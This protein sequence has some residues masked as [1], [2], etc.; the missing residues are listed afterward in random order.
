MLIV[1]LPEDLQPDDEHAT[2]LHWWLLDRE[3]CL[4]ESGCDTPEN[5]RGRFTGQRLRA[6]APATAV[7]LYRLDMPLRRAA[8]VRAALPFA[9]EDQLS[10]DLDL[11][12][13]VPGPRRSDGRLAAAVVETER[14]ERWQA[15]FDSRQWRLEALIPLP[16]LHGDE[17]P[18]QGL[19]VRPSP[20]PSA[21]P[22]VLITAP[23]E[24]P[25]L[26]ET[27]MLR[28]WLTRRLGTLPEA[29]RVIQAHGLSREDL[30]LA[31][32]QSAVFSDDSGSVDL[33]RALAYCLQPSPPLNLLTGPFVSTMAAPPWRKMRPAMV[34][35]G[36]LLAVLLAQFSLEWLFMARERDRL[37]AGIETVFQA[38]LPNSRMVQPVTQFRQVLDGNAPGSSQPGS[39]ALLHEALAV[40]A[41]T[42]NAEVKQFRFSPGELEVELQLTSFAELEAL[43][44][45][46]AAKPR[47]QETLQGADSGSEGVTA[48]LKVSRRAS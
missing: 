29:E 14:M 19:C 42:P 3:G 41:Q 7:S 18:S 40:I 25:V 38:S 28:L 39:S 9:L 13:C 16:I 35:A 12:H 5:L 27:G 44:A 37:M 24:E 21:V 47:L 1:L 48:R 20:W 6:L 32:D 46:L 8:A 45:G 22:Q 31:D 2:S 15:L 33:N 26:I 43:R 17:A 23:D 36:V 34:A 4:Q 11:L 10:Q 30:G